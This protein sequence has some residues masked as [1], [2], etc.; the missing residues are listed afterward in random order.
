M[1]VR[2]KKVHRG[3][4]TLVGRSDTAYGDP[5]TER[6][7]R[8][9]YVIERVSPRLRDPCRR[10]QWSSKFDRNAAKGKL[11]GG[12]YAFEEMMDHTASM[13]QFYDLFVDLSP[14]KVGL[15]NRAPVA[16]RGVFLLL[17]RRLAFVP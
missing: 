10:V 14:G 17:L 16:R 7:R 15:E 4:M 9:G 8:L 6:P 2:G 12:A 11:D 5:T 3:T 1:R 13:W